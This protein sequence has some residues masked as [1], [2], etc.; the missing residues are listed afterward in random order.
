MNKNR[1]VCDLCKA[2][3]RNPFAKCC[4]CG[5]HLCWSCWFGKGY[6]GFA[7]CPD[8]AAKNYVKSVQKVYDELKPHGYII[9]AVGNDGTVILAVP[10]HKSNTSESESGLSHH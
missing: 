1:G 9:E 10:K 8:C 3:P 6:K 4:T 2:S 5:N 7:N